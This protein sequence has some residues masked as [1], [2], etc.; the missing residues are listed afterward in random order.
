[1]NVGCPQLDGLLEKIIYRAHDGCAAGKITKALDVIVALR[2][3][4]IAVFGHGEFVL[5]KPL[6]QGRG[7]VLKRGNCKLDRPT[8]REF[9]G[10][11]GGGVAGIG[12]DQSAAATFLESARKDRHLA[13][14]AVRKW[15]GQ[16]CGGKQ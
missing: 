12:D 5:T 11:N 9:R 16:R 7:D 8:K 14:E 1:M 3:S 6:R 2:W 10:T 15:S 13:K 4:G